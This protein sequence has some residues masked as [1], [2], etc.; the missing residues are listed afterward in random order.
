MT[1]LFVQLDSTTNA[2]FKYMEGWKGMLTYFPEHI[3]AY[4]DSLKGNL[5]TSNVQQIDVSGTKL[6]LTTLNSVYT[7]SIITE[8]E[9]RRL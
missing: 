3:P 8:D 5:R 4:F 2:K 7:F 1:H 6:I 9:A